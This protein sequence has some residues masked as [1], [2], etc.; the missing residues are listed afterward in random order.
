MLYEYQYCFQKKHSTDHALID[1]SEKIRSALYQNM[2]V[3]DIFI[4]L[5]KAID[6]VNHDILLHK[7][8]HYGISSLPNTWLQGFLL[9]RSQYRSIKDKISNKLPMRRGVPQ[10]SVLGPLPFIFSINNRNKA[11]IHGYVHHFA[12]DTNLL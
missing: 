6:T 5:K 4:I 12:D 3:C 8:D 7:L 1:I 11:I 2:F 9:G 10:G